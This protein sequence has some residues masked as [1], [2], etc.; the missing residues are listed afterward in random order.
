MTAKDVI[1]HSMGLSRSVLTQYLADLTDE[2]LMVRPVPG[3][4]HIAWQLGHLIICENGL[5]EIGYPMPALPEGFAESYTKETAGSDDPAKFHKKA[6]YIEL[7]EQQ[8]AAA[9]AHLEALPDADLDKPGPEEARAYAPTVGAVF[10]TLGLHD[11]MHASQFTVV[12]RR[13]G[14][15]PL[16]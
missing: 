15:P 9:L 2:D 8:R 16:F 10:N 7:L 6:Q 4:N 3:A 5:N 12:R 11:M 13:L 1:R 14:K